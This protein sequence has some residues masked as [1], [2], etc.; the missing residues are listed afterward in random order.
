MLRKLAGRLV[1]L[2]PKKGDTC[3]NVDT[4]RAQG[5]L[6]MAHDHDRSCGSPGKTSNDLNE[7][8]GPGKSPKVNARKLNAIK[9]QARRLDNWGLLIG[10]F[11]LC[12]LLLSF[13]PLV[14][15]STLSLR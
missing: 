4:S 11:P 15:S 8:I 13:H 1:F 5:L 10:L 2:T 12:V 7:T 14:M 9:R 6:G 3:T